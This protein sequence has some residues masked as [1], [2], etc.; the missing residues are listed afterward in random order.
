M[1]VID[2]PINKCKENSES[3]NNDLVTWKISDFFFEFFQLIDIKLEIFFQYDCSI[4]NKYILFYVP[5]ET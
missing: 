5:L 4:D 1:K 3:S 2:M